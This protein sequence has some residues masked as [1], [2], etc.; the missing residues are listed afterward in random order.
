VGI[1]AF[2]DHA[3][4]YFIGDAGPA[5]HPHHQAAPAPATA[6]LPSPTGLA[7]R[8]TTSS[9]PN[10][11]GTVLA[12]LQMPPRALVRA[13]AP[14]R[15]PTMIEGGSL[16]DRSLPADATHAGLIQ[17]VERSLNHFRALFQQ[18]MAPGLLEGA[19]DYDCIQAVLAAF[20]D[21]ARQLVFLNSSRE[22]AV[23]LD[24][25]D[26][27]KVDGR[28]SAV[29]RCDTDETD[30]SVAIQVEHASEGST[31]LRVIESLDAGSIHFAITRRE[32]ESALADRP[33]TQLEHHSVPVQARAI[34][35]PI[36]AAY[37]A[38][39]A[40]DCVDDTQDPSPFIN[41]PS[42]AR[43]VESVGR[44]L[45]VEREGI[46]SQGS[47]IE[48]SQAFATLKD[49]FDAHACDETDRRGQA[50]SNSIERLRM[51][52]LERTAKWLRDTPT[53]RVLERVRRVRPADEGGFR[54]L[55]LIR[56]SLERG[57][58]VSSFRM[59][60]RH[61]FSPA[62]PFWRREDEK[63]PLPRAAPVVVRPSRV[64]SD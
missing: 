28:Y 24:A 37:L 59:L 64:S 63:S 11:G 48:S 40:P 61:S 15:L 49:Y 46:A 8:R 12:D 41:A 27:Q 50:M 36:H 32:L 38:L 30:H 18:G 51:D 31:R 26:A 57:P 42:L 39:N 6:T 60:P 9:A 25:L 23:W 1:S 55:G 5:N 13:S 53:E 33:N 16:D 62:A 3:L 20:D 17:T 21:P 29:F 22:L 58:N 4:N 52:M 35:C 2:A 44:L 34:G 14:Q 10:A 56:Q 47:V 45:A 54:I 19:R 7:A 43:H